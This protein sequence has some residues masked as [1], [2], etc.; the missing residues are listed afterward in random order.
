MEEGTYGRVAKYG[1]YAIKQFKDIDP[2]HGVEQNMIREMMVYTRCGGKEGICDGRFR[3]LGDSI[4][5]V[6]EQGTCDLEDYCYQLER[7]KR[8][9]GFMTILRKICIG[10]WNLHQEGFVH[11]DIKPNNIIICKDKSIKLI[12]FGFSNEQHMATSDYEFSESLVFK[13]ETIS[14]KSDVCQIGSTML[15]FL[16]RKYYNLQNIYN[17]LDTL[18]IP[19][20]FARIIEHMIDKDVEKRISMEGLLEL[21]NISPEYTPKTI[22]PTIKPNKEYENLEEVLDS[23]CSLRLRM[24]KKTLDQIELMMEYVHDTFVREYGW[25]FTMRACTLIASKM[26]EGSYLIPSEIT[27]DKE[28]CTRLLTLEKKILERLEFLIPLS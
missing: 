11:R 23:V 16:K 27:K 25:V 22:T 21:L 17:R 14:F 13:D 6:M 9:R 1:N 4:E 8:V 3:M 19:D 26:Y 15:F 7:E 2:D 24:R 18:N 5:L 28:E 10:V 20:E 12:D